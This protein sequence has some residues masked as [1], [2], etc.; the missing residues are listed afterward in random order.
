MGA[1]DIIMTDE[2]HEEGMI[3]DLTN[4]I[5]DMRKTAGLNSEDHIGL[6]LYTDKELAGVLQTYGREIMADTLAYNLLIS[7]SLEQDKPSFEEI[8]RERI[9]P[10]S[11][12]KLENYTVDVLI[13]RM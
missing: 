6:A 9:S 3:C 1:L 11:P 8:Y 10:D 12:K 4:F 7:I 13:G 2:L 5:Q